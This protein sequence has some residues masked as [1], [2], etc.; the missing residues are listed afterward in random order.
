MFSRRAFLATATATALARPAFAT[1]PTLPLR[2]IAA[3]RG[4]LYGS[5][6]DWW[7]FQAH[8][9][10]EALAARE[11]GLMVSARMD[12]DHLAPSPAETQFKEVDQDYDWAHTRNMKFRG[13]ALVWGERAPKWF[14]DLPNR[15]A[16]VEAVEKHVTETCRHFAGR[17][18]SWDVV[19]EP[20]EPKD[21]R[22]DGL[23]TGVFLEMVGPDYLDVETVEGGHGVRLNLLQGAL[24]AARSWPALP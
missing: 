10:Y 23:R 8:R 7:D 13:H 15:A 16:A 14:A 18:Q 11:C 19:N 3:E 21:G 1:Q 4:L 6:L 5:Y 9:D 20:I 12:W 22:P 24:C 2:D 17:M